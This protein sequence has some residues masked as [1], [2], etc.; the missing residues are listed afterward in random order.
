[1]R[2]YFITLKG[3]TLT[4]IAAVASVTIV[5]IILL[6]INLIAYAS[7]SNIRYYE[8]HWGLEFPSDIKTEYHLSI[9][10]TF[11]AGIE[12]SVFKIND[13]TNNLY[14]SL[15]RL[16]GLEEF[17]LD[18]NKMLSDRTLNVLQE[19]DKN[20]LPKWEERLKWGLREGRTHISNNQEMCMFVIY[21]PDAMRLIVCEYRIANR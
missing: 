18:F 14:E 8:K 21:F 19:I 7:R 10:K 13:L 20:F 12:Y 15:N 4:L 1:M 9:S 16:P 5:L 6:V 3:R 17:K 11:N 2:N